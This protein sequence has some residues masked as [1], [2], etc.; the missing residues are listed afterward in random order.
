MERKWLILATATAVAVAFSAVLLIM[1]RVDPFSASW[2]EKGLFF[3]SVLLGVAAL[4][5]LITYLIF[6][7]K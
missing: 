3:I 2:F 1:F 4:I 7:V 5:L 6:R